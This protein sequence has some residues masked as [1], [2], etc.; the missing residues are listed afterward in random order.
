M[1]R[2]GR[3]ARDIYK[4]SDRDGQ[5][6]MSKES[7]LAK[8]TAIYAAG[9]LGSKVLAYVMVLVYTYFIT[10][11]E[12]GYYDVVITTI[13]MLQPLI[14]FQIND[15]VYRHLV[16][17]DRQKQ[18][19]IIGNGIKFLCFTTVAAEIVFAVVCG[20]YAFTYAVWIGLLFASTMF[21]VLFQDIIRGLG[22]SKFYAAIGLLNSLVMLVCETVGLIGF[23]LGVIALIISKTIANTVCVIAMLVRQ[24][25]VKGALAIRLQK[26]VIK[27]I[28]RYSAPLVP[29]TICWWIVNSSD[30]YIILAFL[31]GSFNGIYAM[32]TKFPTILTMITSIFYLAWQESAI[33]EYDSPNRNAFFS[34]IFQKYSVLLFTLCI[35]AIPATK[36]VIELFVSS[37]YK[38]A[39]RYTGFLYLGAL[40]SALCSFLG[41]GYQISKETE[42]SL[43]TTVFAACLNIGVNIGLI[44][45]IG[46]QAASLSTFFAYL[47]LFIVRLKHTKRYFTLSVNWK[48]F[49]ALCGICLLLT[50]WTLLSDS[51]VLCWILCI[52]TFAGLVWAN[53]TLWKPVYQKLRRR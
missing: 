43:A 12:L 18:K 53:Q 6:T 44:R 24:A 20:F 5:E 1:R 42:R 31:G 4:G 40:F 37:A 25:E 47:F 49:C 27:P 38:T 45:V 13:S 15:G 50:A 2:A 14:L 9:N 36:L 52:V 30:R 10:P 51:L 29:N 23:D 7:A 33:K 19:D 17:A 11:E 22:Q 34:D 41:L 32:A 26:E 8:R 21:F 39:W 35:C 48:Q 46:L 28:I 3:Y 16:D